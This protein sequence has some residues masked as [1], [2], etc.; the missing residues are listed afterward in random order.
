V[1]AEGR[2]GEFVIPSRY[3]VGWGFGTRS[4]TPFFRAEIDAMN[5]V[6]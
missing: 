5:A 2:F 6:P 3:S 1:H 4:Y